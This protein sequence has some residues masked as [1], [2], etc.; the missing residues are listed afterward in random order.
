MG[1]AVFQI[2]ILIQLYFI[3]KHKMLFFKSLTCIF[4]SLTNKICFFKPL[5]FLFFNVKE[6]PPFFGNKHFIWNAHIY[7]SHFKVKLPWKVPLIQ[8]QSCS[9]NICTVSEQIAENKSEPKIEPEREK[10][11]KAFSSHIKSYLNASETISTPP[12]Q[13]ASLP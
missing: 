12:K 10:F 2:N 8:P 13:R 7:T 3:I 9:F 6:M 4:K 5:Y 1:L 11:R